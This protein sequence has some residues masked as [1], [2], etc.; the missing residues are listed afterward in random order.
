MYSG[1]RIDRQFYAGAGYTFDTR[2]LPSSLKPEFSLQ[3]MCLQRGWGSGKINYQV[4]NIDFR[5][6]NRL[7]ADLHTKWRVATRI[8]GGKMIPSYDIS[9]L[10]YAKESEVIRRLFGKGIII[11][12]HHLSYFIRLLKIG[13]GFQFCTYY[14]ESAFIYRV[15][16]YAE[17]FGDAGTVTQRGENIK[18]NNFVSGCGL[19]FTLLILPYNIFR[20][21]LAFNNYFKSE[22]LVDLGVSF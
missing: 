19:G 17:I 15:A 8:T 16:L 3:L 2:I 9:F 6:Y 12:L 21:E 11:M 5:N 7:F 20:I 1:E 22:I 18:I 14:P 4:Y 10:G 13:S